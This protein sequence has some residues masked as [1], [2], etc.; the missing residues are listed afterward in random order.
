MEFAQEEAEANF[1][2]KNGAFVV[3][4]RESLRWKALLVKPNIE[5]SF[6]VIDQVCR[7]QWCVKVVVSRTCARRGAIRSALYCAAV[8]Q[9][10]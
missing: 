10:L 7:V 5:P 9:R 2:G 6:V 4:G 1:F 3:R 8:R